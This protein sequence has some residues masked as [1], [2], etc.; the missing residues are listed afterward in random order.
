M[1]VFTLDNGQIIWTSH[2]VLAVLNSYEDRQT[3]D[4]ERKGLGTTTGG[5]RLG[6]LASHR[7]HFDYPQN[8][9]HFVTPLPWRS[10][11]DHFFVQCEFKSVLDDLSVQTTKSSSKHRLTRRLNGRTNLA[12]LFV[13]MCVRPVFT[14][15]DLSISNDL[16]VF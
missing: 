11:K 3:K 4:F 5:L 10:K 9:T 12:D 1:A 16:S 15:V 13:Q 7:R 2:L 8:N 14:L 6:Y